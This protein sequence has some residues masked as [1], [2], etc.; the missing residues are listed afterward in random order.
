MGARADAATDQVQ[1]VGSDLPDPAVALTVTM[2]VKLGTD[3]NT[4]STLMRF[5]NA[6]GSTV[7]NFALGANGTVPSYFTGGGSVAAPTDLIP[8]LW[9]P[10]AFRCAAN[11]ARV[12]VGNS[13]GQV[14]FANSGSVSGSTGPNRV[15]LFGR[16]FGDTSERFDGSLAYVRVFA[17]E[18]T[19]EQIEA[20]W[21]TPTSSTPRVADWPL[22]VASLLDSSGNAKHLSA[23][24][25][26]LSDDP[27]PVFDTDSGFWIFRDDAWTQGPFVQVFT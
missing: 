17:A 11:T 2:W 3:L 23:G 14:A 25:T 7:A 5:S 15:A 24:T 12:F 18:L 21:Q 9:T 10:L 27:G 16:G 22:E 20:E 13:L 26:P 4:F 19:A 8:G 1:Y 6:G